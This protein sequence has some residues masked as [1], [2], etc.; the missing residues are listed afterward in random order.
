MRVQSIR[1]P[2]LPGGA[3][4]IIDDQP[5]SVIM[6]LRDDLTAE[7]VAEL[8]AAVWAANTSQGFYERQPP[9]LTAA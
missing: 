5:G 6:W 9:I 7:D 1:V 3:S 4:C 8:M 2:D